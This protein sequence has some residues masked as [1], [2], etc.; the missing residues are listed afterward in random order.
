MFKH[1][2]PLSLLAVLALAAPAVA[3][4]SGT[5]QPADDTTTEAPANEPSAEPADDASGEDQLDLGNSVDDGELKPGDRYSKKK[6]DDWDLA[7]IKTDAET[8]P[9]SLLQILT[10]DTGNPIAEYSLF[11]ISDGNQAVA[12]ATIIAL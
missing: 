12:G 4:Q 7:C 10:D 6:F 11:R 1:L 9:C 2:T 8:D 5:T 3:Q